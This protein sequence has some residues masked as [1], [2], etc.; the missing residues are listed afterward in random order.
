LTHY[1]SIEII[2]AEPHR[3]MHWTAS[4]MRSKN[5]SVFKTLLKTMSINPPSPAFC[6]TSGDRALWLS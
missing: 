6:A 3:Q 1:N 4:T 2:G 5:I